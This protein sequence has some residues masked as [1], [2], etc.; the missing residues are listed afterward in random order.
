[1]PAEYVP[2]D[3]QRA[4]V[5]SASAF[6]VPNGTVRLLHTRFDRAAVLSNLLV[7]I[8]LLS[9]PCGERSTT[10]KREA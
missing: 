3:A 2:T 10:G 5:E 6:G 9:S 7:D 4:L 1:M 8:G